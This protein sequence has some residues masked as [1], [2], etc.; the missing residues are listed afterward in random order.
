MDAASIL[1]FIDA[2][3]D[4][5]IAVDSKV[6]D[7][8]RSEFRLTQE[9]RSHSVTSHPLWEGYLHDKSAPAAGAWWRRL[10]WMWSP[11]EPPLSTMWTS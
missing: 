10:G 5:V 2:G 3:R 7:E 4:V 9:I 1:E 6:S 8:I 11:G